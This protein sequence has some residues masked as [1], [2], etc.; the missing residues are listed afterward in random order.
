[1]EKDNRWIHKSGKLVGKQ[2]ESSALSPWRR[3]KILSTRKPRW[4]AYP[5][6]AGHCKRDMRG[7]L[8]SLLEWWHWQVPFCFQTRRLPVL[9]F[10]WWKFIDVQ[11]ELPDSSNGWCRDQK[12]LDV[13]T[14]R[15]SN[16]E[17]CENRKAVY[18][19]LSKG[20]TITRATPSFNW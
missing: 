12:W 1:M 17:V 14:S 4:S 7:L 15:M 16:T 20:G 5:G 9:W 8:P 3:V 11:K 13:R 18:L 2:T 19:T 6:M 10:G